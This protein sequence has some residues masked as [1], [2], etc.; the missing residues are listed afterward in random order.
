[1][2]IQYKTLLMALG[3][4]AMLTSCEKND[5]LDPI[6]VPGQK[7][8]TTYWEVGSTTCKAGESFTFL[9]KYNLDYEGAS[10]SYSEVWYRIVR[11]ESAAATVKLAGASLSYT[12]TVTDNQ[13]VRSYQPIVRYNHDKAEWAGH[14]FRVNGVVPVSSTLKPINW[15][16]A[17]EWDAD[18]FAQYYPEGFASEFNSEVIELLTKDST[19]Y[20][21]L[22]QVYIS[23]PFTMEQFAEV[24]S[25]YNLAFPTNIDMTKD[26]NGAAEKSDAWFS[27]TTVAATDADI[28]GWYYTTLDANGNKIV[29]E[30][31]KDVVKQE[32]INY[33]A[34]YKSAAWVFCR[35]DDDLGAIIST[36]RAAY[37]PAF[38]DLLGS[39]TFD[40]W[41][42]DSSNKAYKVEFARKYSLDAQF[43]VYDTLGGEGIAS[44]VRT[45]LIN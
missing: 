37:I 18:R 32:G 2:K 19:Y 1:M 10:P 43:R 38:K 14:E 22:R 29:H 5:P 20:N 17:A 33:Y 34:V 44:D 13:V 6:V 40:Q 39:I 9:G 7:V 45:I 23:H 36:V 42:Y 12:K 25:K 21:A 11:E 16:D 27:T 28:I 8:P 31:P 24:N 35:Y 41:I 3:A 15:K 30:V 26:D 4:V